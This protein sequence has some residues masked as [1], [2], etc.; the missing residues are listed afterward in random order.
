MKQ[1]I[2]HFFI[3]LFSIFF[4]GG[5]QP[6]LI[7]PTPSAGD[8]DFSKTVAIGGNYMAG[9]QDGALYRKGQELS[10]PALLA[11]KFRMVGAPPFNQAL[12]PDNQGLGLSTKPWEGW[13]VSPSRLRM[14][15]DC[16]GVTALSP[17]KD[18]ISE[19]AAS[20]YLVGIAG[21]SIENMAVP[22]ATTADYF[23][24]A[25]G[26]AFSPSG[27]HNPYYNRIAGN[28]GI[29]TMYEDAI[30]QH[31][32]FFLAWM[33][34]EDI[35]NYAAI[36][37]TGPALPSSLAFE[38]RLDSM[39]SGMCANGAKGAIA[40]IPDF[41]SYPYYTLFAW[42]NA[43]LT[44]QTLADTLNNIYDTLAGLPNVHFI[45]GRNGFVIDNPEY[46]SSSSYSLR[47]LHAGE[48]ITLSVPIDSIKCELYGLLSYPINDR[49]ALDSAEVYGIDQAIGSYNAII[50]QKAAQYGLAIVDM[51]N[52]FKTVVSG[53]KWDGAD[54]NA[55]FV[56]GGF[57]SLDGYHPN[58]KGYALIANEFIKAI[59]IKYNAVIP[60]V[61]CKDCNGV[62]FP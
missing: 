49:Y 30:N 28:P 2:L 38:S 14:K 11:E 13:F 24:P 23:N 60:F 58:Q 33:G 52:Y 39:L 42:D 61:N 10:I 46:P 57:L 6:E 27:N 36:G 41:R 35:Y 5:C 15:T 20:P 48:Y 7:P 43:L 19:S 3:F 51:N 37:A 18:Y 4:I 9:Y 54:L 21:N 31:A 53:I 17:I 16:K 1:P 62:L 25:F 50:S 22:F 8:A 45:V 12:M 47:Q 59:N 34:M 26:N 44:R 29:S 32:T 56:S 55:T 40:N